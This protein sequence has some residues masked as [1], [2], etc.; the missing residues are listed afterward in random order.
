MHAK[1]AGVEFVE[2][3]AILFAATQAMMN[4][5][6]TNTSDKSHEIVITFFA[7]F[8][9]QHTLFLQHA[10]KSGV[11]VM[12]SEF[13]EVG[14]GIQQRKEGLDSRQWRRMEDGGAHLCK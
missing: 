6:K 4:A 9:Q 3:L 1:A 7:F 11:A 5:Q 10:V 13:T 12:M 14:D 2:V 8:I